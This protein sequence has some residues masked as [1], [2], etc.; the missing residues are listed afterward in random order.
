MMKRFLNYIA[1]HPIK[2]IGLCTFLYTLYAAGTKLATEGYGAEIDGLMLAPWVTLVAVSV[3]MVF[4]AVTGLFNWMRIRKEWKR[5][6]VSG[7]AV[8]FLIISG[9]VLLA[10]KI[11]KLTEGATLQKALGVPMSIVAILIFLKAERSRLIRDYYQ[12]IGG[13]LALV[14]IYLNMK[15]ISGGSIARLPFFVI[16]LLVMYALGC[17]V[18]TPIM[19]TDKGENKLEFGAGEQP[20]STLIVFVSCALLVVGNMTVLPD[21][22]QG[23]LVKMQAGL[24]HP[25]WKMMM[26]AFIIGIP[27]GLYAPT[28]VL[29]LMYNG[30]GSTAMLGYIMQKLAGLGGATLGLPTLHLFVWLFFSYNENIKVPWYD[31]KEIQA[32][33]L[34]F[35]ATFISLI[36]QLRAYRRLREQEKSKK[37]LLSRVATPSASPA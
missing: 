22:L 27:F 2:L 35:S 24:L 25:T 33:L 1:Q 4:Y 26:W 34:F 13:T 19:R 17:L 11:I 14:A 12:L 18:R 15:G 20:F 5:F 30:G 9:V 21:Q 32:L 6:L 7:T 3:N 16:I 31:M 29:L 28:S 23:P 36:P 8:G 10:L 37:S